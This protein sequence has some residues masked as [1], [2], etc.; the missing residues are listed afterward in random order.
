[1]EGDNSK[2][3]FTPGHPNSIFD[4]DWQYEP[5]LIYDTEILVFE[6]IVRNVDAITGTA[7]IECSS[8]NIAKQIQETTVT[9]SRTKDT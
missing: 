1:M 5:V 6:G 7:Q 3:V 4:L 8:K 2:D 9:R